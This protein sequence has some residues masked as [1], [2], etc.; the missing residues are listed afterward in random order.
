MKLDKELSNSR[1][2]KDSKEELLYSNKSKI[3]EIVRDMK[4]MDINYP[5]SYSKLTDI[6]NFNAIVKNHELKRT[7]VKSAYGEGKSGS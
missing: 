2:D 7:H 6:K 5:Q 4:S 3:D 1:I